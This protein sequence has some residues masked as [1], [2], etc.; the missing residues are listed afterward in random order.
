[1]ND[2]SSQPDAGPATAPAPGEAGP[3]H[4]ASQA[5]TVAIGDLVISW[6]DDQPV[7]YGGPEDRPGR[8]TLSV[9][10]LARALPVR[11]CDPERVAPATVP[12]PER[13]ARV[14]VAKRPRDEMPYAADGPW[15][16][17][18]PGVVLPSWHRTKRDA[19]A[20][21]LRRLAIIDWRASVTP[22]AG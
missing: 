2:P 14:N 19:T 7:Q 11:K 17:T 3:G 22:T 10:L 5:G 6:Y 20:T 12:I 15:K 9:Q 13:D 18:L 21:G 16:L 8:S 1:M 4:P